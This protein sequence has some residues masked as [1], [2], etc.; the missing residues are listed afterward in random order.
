MNSRE[1]VPKIS[2]TLFHWSISSASLV[3]EID[4]KRQCDRITNYQ[5][6]QTDN[7]NTIDGRQM[8]GKTDRQTDSSTT[9]RYLTADAFPFTFVAEFSTGF[10][11][12][13][14]NNPGG[15]PDTQR[16]RLCVHLIWERKHFLT[17]PA[18]WEEVPHALESQIYP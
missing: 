16:K 2:M 4:W 7:T 17:P 6:I 5:Y 15:Q 11:Q 14:H 3:K 9:D 13:L 10:H 8:S 18:C 12:P 1:G